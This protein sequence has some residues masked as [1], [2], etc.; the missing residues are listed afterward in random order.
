MDNGQFLPF[1][2]R[3]FP[4]SLTLRSLSF[5]KIIQIMD[6]SPIATQ[7]VDPNWATPQLVDGCD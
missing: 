7:S 1:P 5:G 3:P 6:D 2:C 4:Q